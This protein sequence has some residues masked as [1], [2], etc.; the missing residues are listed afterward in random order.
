MRT[1]LSEI[2]DIEDHLLGKNQ[3]EALLL[4]V[5]KQ[6][7]NYKLKQKVELQ[8]TVHELACAYGRKQLKTEI[9]AVHQEL[10]SQSANRS[11]RQKILQ[12]FY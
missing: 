1:S 4:F 12:L 6:Q 11:F 9:E 10:F 8:K 7:L 2:R 5:A 3:P